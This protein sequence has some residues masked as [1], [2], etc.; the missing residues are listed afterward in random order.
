MP[1][2]NDPIERLAAAD[3]LPGVERLT[4]DEQRAADV[5]LA[6]IVAEQPEPAPRAS[7]RPRRWMLAVAATA[8]GIAVAVTAI[9]VLDEGAPGPSVVDRAVAAVTDGDAIYHTIG[10]VR[11]RPIE[12]GAPRPPSQSGYIEAWYGPNHV[13]HGKWYE[14]RGGRRGRLSFEGAER[15]VPQG[16]G[17]FRATGVSYD[18]AHNT[19]ER[20]RT[21]IG[22]EG[23][24]NG[25]LPIVDPNSDPGEGMRRLQ[26]EGRLRLAGSE[27]FA[28]EKVY[29]LVSGPVRRGSHGLE[30]YTYLVDAETYYPVFFR[31]VLSR[32]GTTTAFE[33]RFLTY[34]RIPFDA[35]GRKLLELDPHPGAKEIRNPVPSSG[36]SGGR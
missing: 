1:P 5:L 16:H 29:R 9:D 8:C 35:Q 31:W 28:G 27:R 19:I 7:R 30:R 15:L 20:Y 10:V 17:R 25:K 3:P 12:D 11:I 24:A 14:L 23:S 18:S 2:A 33:A 13:T 32:G 34:E 4:E 22:T 21:A 26:R 6:R 36:G